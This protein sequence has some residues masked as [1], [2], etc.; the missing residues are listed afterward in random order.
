MGRKTTFKEAYDLFKKNNCELLYSEEEFNKIF[1][2]SN[3]KLN[4][5]AIC[6]HNHQIQL[7]I[8]KEGKSE[9]ICPSCVYKKRSLLYKEAQSGKNKNKY[10]QLESESITYLV[11]HLE[12]TF[13]IIKTF[14]SCIS[15]IIIKPKN[16]LDDLWLGVQIKSTNSHN[17]LSK[18][19]FFNIKKDYENLFILCICYQDKKIW[20]FENNDIKH[21][22]NTLQIG[23]ESNSKYNKFEITNNLNNALLNKYEKLNKFTKDLLLNQLSKT[24]LIE[25]NYYKYR[26]SKIN[27]INFIKNS[28][29]GEVFD[30]KIGNKKVQEK[31]GKF[32]G[33]INS[34]IYNYYDFNLSK[35]NGK[36]NKK[37]PYCE[38]D[39]D[40]YWFNCKDTTQFYV[41]PEFILIEKGYIGK[42]TSIIISKENVNKPWL[43][44]Y[45]FDYEALEK[46]KEKLC[47][48][49]L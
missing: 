47:K 44:D 27:F 29:Q 23:F 5:I 15:D 14:D 19:Y 32:K 18:S 45:M 39:N 20:G 41:I 42:K 3:T 6:G 7:R 22:K 28:N 49:L 8:F 40:I 4:Y 21:L 34:K 36:N 43:N 11:S 1:V 17:N 35:C 48:I 25:Y 2:N 10:M 24:T 33:I 16:I 9:K 31:V 37:I 13:D 12:K 46:D 30:F 26:E 38:K